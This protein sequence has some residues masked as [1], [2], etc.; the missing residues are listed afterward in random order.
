MRVT[1]ELRSR[2]DRTVVITVE[3]EMDLVSAPRVLTAVIEA[4]H[5]APEL[6]VLDLAGVGYID[7]SG[8]S[9]VVRAHR[10]TG[11]SGCRLSVRGATAQVRHLFA[12]TGVDRVVPLD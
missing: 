4:T 3:G 9:E 8:L 5:S 1:T 11:W 10:F 2:P 12:T 7:A 6:V